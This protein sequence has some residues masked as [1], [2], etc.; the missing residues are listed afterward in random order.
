M[1]SVRI[2]IFVAILI[3]NLSF[4]GQCNKTKSRFCR[5]K[6]D[7]CQKSSNNQAGNSDYWKSAKLATWSTIIHSRFKITNVCYV[8]LHVA[9]NSSRLQCPFDGQ[10]ECEE[11][12]AVALPLDHADEDQDDLEYSYSAEYQYEYH[13]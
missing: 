3:A 8:I 7:E 6:L 2:C 9:E 1:F 5:T 4:V 11:G 12:G 13:K 10:I